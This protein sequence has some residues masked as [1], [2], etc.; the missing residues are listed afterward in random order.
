M[1]SIGY[2]SW[3]IFACVSG[4]RARTHAVGRKDSLSTRRLCRSYRQL[5]AV[6]FICWKW[7]RPRF[8]RFLALEDAAGTDAGL[9][10]LVRNVRSLERNPA[11]WEP[12]RRKIA[13]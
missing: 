12:V 2:G 6:L 3:A 1:R 7:S 9:A 4:H 11:K 5:S 13:R 10:K 8:G